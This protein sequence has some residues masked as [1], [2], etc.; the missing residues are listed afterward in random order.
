MAES[1][2]M[3]TVAPVNWK[4]MIWAVVCASRRLADDAHTSLDLAECSGI[5]AFILLAQSIG[6]E[7]MANGKLWV[8]LNDAQN[9]PV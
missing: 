5:E 6:R 8:R 4:R 7:T 9:I 3:P 1:P 2:D